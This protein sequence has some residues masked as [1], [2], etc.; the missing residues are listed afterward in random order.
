VGPGGGLRTALATLH[1]DL[2]DLRT[3][4][5]EQR[6]AAREDLKG[7][8]GPFVNLNMK[9]MAGERLCCSLLPSSLPFSLSSRL[10]CVWYLP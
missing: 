7:L 5:Q 3:L 9:R 4:K 2:A 1:G 6:E 8:K 10:F